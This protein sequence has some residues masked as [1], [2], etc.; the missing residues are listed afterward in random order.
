LPAAAQHGTAQQ[1]TAQHAMLVAEAPI[2]LA[3]SSNETGSVSGSCGSQHADGLQVQAVRKELSNIRTPAE[4][5]LDE[6]AC[7]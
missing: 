1:D 4:Q 5:L 6:E 7:A 3:V 2:R